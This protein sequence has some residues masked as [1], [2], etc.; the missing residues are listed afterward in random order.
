MQI[1]VK[2]RKSTALSQRKVVCVQ[3]LV[4][5]RCR[6]VKVVGPSYG[7]G[8]GCSCWRKCRGCRVQLWRKVEVQGAGCRVQLLAQGRG[9]G[10]RVQG[11]VVVIGAGCSCC[12]N[13]R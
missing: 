6:Y 8:A 1:R 12:D 3:I 5:D 4:W 11:A 13:V 9:A 10:C 2:A 7:R